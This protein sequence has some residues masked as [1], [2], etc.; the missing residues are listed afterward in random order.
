M[1]IPPRGEV[2]AA[3]SGA[4]GAGVEVG[5]GQRIGPWCVARYEITDGPH[6]IDSPYASVVVKWLRAGDP[7]DP[8]QRAHQSQLTTES[9]ALQFLASCEISAPAVIH[10]DTSLLIMED[11]GRHRSLDELIIDE[12]CTANVRRH[13]INTARELARRH[14]MTADRSTE[15][16]A[17]FG[18]VG[19][20]DP[21][22]ELSRFLDQGWER[23]RCWATE[24]G[25]G[26]DHHAIAEAQEVNRT[27]TRPDGFL[28]LSNGDSATN[29]V[30]VVDD[31][32]MIIDYEFA[33]FRHCLTDLVEFYL[34]GP[35]F[36]AVADAASSG[37][38][39][40]YRAELGQWIPEAAD[41]QA[42]GVG[43]A[44]AGLTHAFVRLANF[45]TC[46]R[47]PRG[48]LSRLERLHGLESAADLAEGRS[49]FPFLTHWCRTLAKTL[50]RRWPDTDIDTN[51]LP[52][53]LPRG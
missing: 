19:N 14:G 34:P 35:R 9:V 27:I 49:A 40:S 50:R 16:Y 4:W 1:P 6:A 12:G 26:P 10:A 17:R 33:G 43:L 45:G 15:Y 25:D 44:A 32:V 36:V 23:T 47:R 53:F 42:F 29:N 5:A 18:G 28:A 13:L 7:D 39:D 24:L 46:D 31:S 51:Q 21:E 3:L 38:E 41:D 22:R 8:G 11:L 30:L 20:V 52:P 2:A 48:D 37:F